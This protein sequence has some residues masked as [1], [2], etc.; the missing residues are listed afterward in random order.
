MQECVLRLC[1]SSYDSE[2]H[3]LRYLKRKPDA[4]DHP[5]KNCVGACAYMQ[6]RAVSGFDS[7]VLYTSALHIRYR[8]HVSIYSFTNGVRY[9]T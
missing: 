3:V 4:A 8:V 1:I 7:L 9:L 6:K 5:R 2:V